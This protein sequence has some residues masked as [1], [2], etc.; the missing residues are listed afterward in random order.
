MVTQLVQYLSIGES[1]CE[2]IME[3]RSISRQNTPAIK[4]IPKITHWKRGGIPRTHLNIASSYVANTKK[5]IFDIWAHSHHRSYLLFVR[6][7]CDNSET[8]LRQDWDN[9]RHCQLIP[10]HIAITAPISS[11]S[12]NLVNKVTMGVLV[13]PPGLQKLLICLEKYSKVNYADDIPKPLP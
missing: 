2:K 12:T 9:F 10:E 7:L 1:T 11:L 3:L 4:N 13:S 6:Q 8:T 5:H